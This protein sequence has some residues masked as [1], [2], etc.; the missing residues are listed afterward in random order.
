MLRRI[1]LRGLGPQALT[2]DSLQ[3]ILPR[4]ILDVAA[5]AEQVRPVCED[6]RRRGAAAVREYTRRFDGVELD[7][8]RVPEQALDDALGKLDS[9]VRAALEES[10]RRTALVHRAQLRAD[11]TAEVARGLT[12]TGRSV[13]VSRAGVY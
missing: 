4:A 5:A 7:A 2:R 8:T 11:P 6:V 3:G 1:D 13:P 9:G 12:V 10:A